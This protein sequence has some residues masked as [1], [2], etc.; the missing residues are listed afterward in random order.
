MDLSGQTHNQTT[1]IHRTQ[2]WVEHKLGLGFERGFQT[3]VVHIVV[4]VLNMP[5]QLLITVTTARRANQNA[6]NS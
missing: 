1:S 5:F 3:H 2:G 4:T 6:L